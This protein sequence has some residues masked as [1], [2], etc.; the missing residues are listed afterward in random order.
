M[1]AGAQRARVSRRLRSLKWAKDSDRWSAVAEWRWGR[2][3]GARSGRSSR[4]AAAARRGRC[5]RSRGRRARASRP[6]S[7]TASVRSR[8][9]PPLKPNTSA[10]SGYADPGSPSP[11]SAPWPLGRSSTPALLSMP[12]GVGQQHPR[13]DR[14]GVRVG[15]GRAEQGRQPV[16]LGGGVV[17]QQRHVRR[18]DGIERAGPRRRRNPRSRLRPGRRLAGRLRDELGRPVGRG[19]VHDQE[20]VVERLRRSDSRHGPSRW[21]PCHVT[22]TTVTRGASGGWDIGLTLVEVPSV[23]VTVVTRLLRRT[24]P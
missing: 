13:G 16:R 1:P 21:R 15:V 17:V 9:A 22:T 14:G 5:P 12:A 3:R 2:R 11:R 7:R 20:A 8:A 10:G 19:V 24:F 23:P 6:T 18:V 4:P